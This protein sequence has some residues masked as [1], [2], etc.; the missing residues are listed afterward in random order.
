VMIAVGGLTDFAAGNRASIV[1]VVN[2][3]TRQFGVRLNDLVNRGDISANA[4]M[5]PGDI[6]VIP[7]TRF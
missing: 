7:E 3:E 5:L 6:L 4:Q 1:R 2:G